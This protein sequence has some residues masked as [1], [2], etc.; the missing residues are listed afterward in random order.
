MTPRGTREPEQALLRS[1][2]RRTIQGF[3]YL[4]MYSGSWRRGPGT[5]LCFIIHAPLPTY[6]PLGME[7]MMSGAMML[8]GQTRIRADSEG[9]MTKRV[10]GREG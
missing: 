5:I 9:M 6:V 1:F 3:R 10:E 7:V 4:G 8:R 2:L